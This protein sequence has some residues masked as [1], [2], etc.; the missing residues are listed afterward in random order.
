[1]PDMRNFK[2]VLFLIDTFSVRTFLS[3]LTNT[4]FIQFNICWAGKVVQSWVI[5][6]ILLKIWW[7]FIWQSRAVN[8]IARIARFCSVINI[9]F[10]FENGIKCFLIFILFQ[11]SHGIVLRTEI[12]HWGRI[13]NF[14]SKIDWGSFEEVTFLGKNILFWLSRRYI[15]MKRFLIN[16][17]WIFFGQLQPLIRVV[18]TTRER[19]EAWI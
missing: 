1:M 9:F 19:F 17:F 18:F 8:I 14:L 6:R 11:E 15:T 13:D 7:F 12:F 5:D 4:N 2:L 10:L 16:S 3:W